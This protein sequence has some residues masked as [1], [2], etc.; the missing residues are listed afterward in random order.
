[1]PAK[2]W[3]KK[4]RDIILKNKDKTPQELQKMLWPFHRTT[5][6]ISDA[7]Y[8]WQKRKGKK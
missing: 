1:M 4:T 2:V 5:K 8:E 3:N 6:Q 7:R